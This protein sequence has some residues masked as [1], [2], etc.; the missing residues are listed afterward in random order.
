MSKKPLG[1]VLCG[2][3]S[4]RM[5]QQK[6]LLR[7]DSGGTYLQHAIKRLKDIC[8]DVCIAGSPSEDHSATAEA[9]AENTHR[10]DITLAD[11]VLY[12]GPVVG[13]VSGLQFAKEA[14]LSACLV[15]PV[16]MPNLTV[17]DLRKLLYA[18]RSSQQLTIV[19]NESDQK[20][21]PLVGIY[22][23][24][25]L[26]AMKQLAQNDDRSLHRWLG[27]Q[28]HQAIALSDH[29]CH[30]VNRPEDLNA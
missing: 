23:V 28:T 12:Q 20:L 24:K 17:D 21:Q 11:P 13:I 10:D 14:R 26:G 19:V 29:A 2:G 1:V 6:S 15:T 27:Q 22:P 18:W 3:Q 16:D 8:D 7:H 5:G 30:N 25:I 9:S 4:S